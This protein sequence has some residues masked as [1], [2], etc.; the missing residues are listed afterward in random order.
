MSTVKKIVVLSLISFV[1][2]LSGCSSKNVKS[3]LTPDDIVELYSTSQYK[4]LVEEVTAAAED[5]GYK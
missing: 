5:A 4:T 3:N 2:M 1:L